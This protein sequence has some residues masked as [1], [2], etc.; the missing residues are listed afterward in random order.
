M[1]GKGAFAKSDL[2]KIVAKVNTGAAFWGAGQAQKEIQ[3]GVTAKGA[4]GAVTV[5]KGTL[6]ADL[7]AM[8]ESAEQ[9]QTLTKLAKDQLT[10]VLGI[11][12]ANPQA[13]P[14][15]AALVKAVTVTNERDEV[16]VTANVSEQDV[17]T[18]INSPMF[19][20]GEP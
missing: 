12:N 10:T 6:A 11:V 2:G 9:A 4:Y 7:H 14:S 13:G 18:A 17:L 3:P 1:S 8:L 16:R 19:G 5:G 15:V 20:A